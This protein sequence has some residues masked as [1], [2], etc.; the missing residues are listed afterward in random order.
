ER[1]FINEDDCK[2]VL[3]DASRDVVLD[4]FLEEEGSFVFSN[5]EDVLELEEAPFER[6][7]LELDM[8]EAIL[9]GIRRLDEWSLVR[10]KLPRDTMRLAIV[11]R[12]WFESLK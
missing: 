4:L 2:R 12:P 1:S 5:K 3:S 6:V 8:E 11:D 7:P 10:S 9:E